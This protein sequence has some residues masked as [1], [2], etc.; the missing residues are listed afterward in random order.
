[1]SFTVQPLEGRRV[2]RPARSAPHP[3]IPRNPSSRVLRRNSSASTALTTFGHKPSGSNTRVLPAIDQNGQ[4]KFCDNC[5]T[6]V[7]PSW[8][9]HPETQKLLCNACGLY[10]RLHRRARPITLDDSGQIQVIRKN[11][12]VQREPINMLQRPTYS[13]RIPSQHGNVGLAFNYMPQQPSSQPI[14]QANTTTLSGLQGMDNHHLL[15]GNSQHMNGLSI[16]SEN[17]RLI[18]G[19]VDNMLQLN[20]VDNRMAMSPVHSDMGWLQD[21]YSSHQN[22]PS[23]DTKPDDIQ[24][25]S[26]EGQKH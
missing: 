20:I 18:P 24:S 19:M 9:R 17:E 13:S 14:L 12:A 25:W 1:M 21:V 6:A 4:Y 23:P 26:E 5:I 16:T 15:T 10:L 3:Y 8:R 11:A 2:L 22:I 7:T